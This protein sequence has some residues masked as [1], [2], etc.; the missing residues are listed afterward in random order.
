[1]LRGQSARAVLGAQQSACCR[2]ALTP[3]YPRTKTLQL[4]NTVSWC[5]CTTA[6]SFS[7]QRVNPWLQ[8]QMCP[9]TVIDRLTYQQPKGSSKRTQH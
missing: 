8:W 2:E 6:C 5:A 9:G 1:M 3:Q 4:L 7:T